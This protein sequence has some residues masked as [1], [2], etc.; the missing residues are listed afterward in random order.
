[1]LTAFD[2]RAALCDNRILVVCAF[3]CAMPAREQVLTAPEHNLRLQEHV[4][5]EIGSMVAM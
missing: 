2:H 5:R 3:Q 4:F 1:M